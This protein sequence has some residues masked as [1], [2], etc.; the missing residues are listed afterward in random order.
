MRILLLT[1][2]LFFASPFHSNAQLPNGS[3]APDFTL[4]DID[5]NTHHLYSYLAQGKAVFIKFFACHCSGCWAYHNTHKLKDIYETYGP[6]G[7]DEIMVIMLEHDE[8]N[9]DAFTGDGG[10]T[11]GVWTL[12]NPV[13]MC[14]VEGGDRSV[15]TNYQMPYYPYIVKVCS[16]RTLESISTSL[17]VAE[18]YQKAVD[19]PGELSIEE[20]NIE[21]E[22]DITISQRQ[23]IVTSTTDLTSISIVN[24]SGQTV[25]ESLHTNEAI[26]LS[27]LESGVY[28]VRVQNN[29]QVITKK[30]YLQ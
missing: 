3:T 29:E 19:C 8:F 11:Q 16:D 6:N 24:T 12:D 1:L 5:G 17:S 30:I 21:E 18:L 14:D 2:A 25:I 7:T 20:E 23:L 28:F 15:F 27:K 22:I 10:F 26:D 9:A 4:T 13:P